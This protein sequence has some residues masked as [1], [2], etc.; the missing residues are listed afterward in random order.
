MIITRC[1]LDIY[2][3]EILGLAQVRSDYAEN[4]GSLLNFGA[5]LATNAHWSL[6]I[7]L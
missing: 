2:K 1:K 4:D 5:L 3:R 7:F 6:D